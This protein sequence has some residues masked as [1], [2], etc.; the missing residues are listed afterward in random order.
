MQASVRGA[1]VWEFSDWDKLPEERREERKAAADAEAA[2][3][4]KGGPVGKIDPNTAS[5]DELM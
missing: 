3:D 2:K 5:R 1:G 4:G